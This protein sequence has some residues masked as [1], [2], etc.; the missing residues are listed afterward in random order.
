MVACT[1]TFRIYLDEQFG[2][3]VP[4]VPYT[5]ISEPIQYMIDSKYGQQVSLF[6]KDSE[7]L[8]ELVDAL[9]NQVLAFHF[10]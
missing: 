10:H 5:S 8:S 2:P 7:Q 4:V 3:V 6:G 1:N 9:T